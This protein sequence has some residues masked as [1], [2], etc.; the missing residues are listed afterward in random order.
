MP[1]PL[2]GI[3]T[4]P[5]TSP[6]RVYLDS[7]LAQIVQAV[8]RSG[9]LP[10]LI[11][12]DL[13]PATLG[14]LAGRFDGILFSGGDDLDPAHYGG[15]A[16][17]TLAAADI[18][19]DRIELDLMRRAVADE[20]PFFGICRGAQVLN[21]ALGGTLY[22]DVCEHPGAHRHTYFPGQPFDQRPHEIQVEEDSI[23][24]R[25]IGRPI[26]SVNSLHHQACRDIAAGLRVAARAPDGIVEAVEVPGHPF[27]L[28]VQWHPEALPDAPEMR[29]LF[30]AFV[31]ASARRPAEASDSR[32]SGAWERQRI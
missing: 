4:H 12:P 25:I 29:A 23:L 13:S 20:I 31:A 21:V 6:Y 5:P 8:E 22:A 32:P 30:E 24:A 9:G 10:A 14:A 17:P 15:A 28:G 27:A 26:L 11:P 2:I 3:T 18:A 7:L 16:I 19:R 1:A